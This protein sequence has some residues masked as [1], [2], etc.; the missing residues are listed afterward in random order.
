MAEDIGAADAEPVEAAKIE[1]ADPADQV[2]EAGLH[3][4][5][6]PG[7]QTSLPE[8]PVTS[9]GALARLHTIVPTVINALG[10]TL[11]VLVLATTEILLQQKKLIENLTSSTEIQVLLIL[12]TETQKYK[13]QILI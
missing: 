12:F 13:R 11:R 4:T 2:K 10:G 3:V 8:R 6:D 9:T 5:G 1:E 7:T